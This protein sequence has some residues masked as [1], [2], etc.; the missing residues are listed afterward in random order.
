MT[1]STLQKVS[2]TLIMIAAIC[3]GSPAAM[4]EKANCDKVRFGQVNWTGVSTKTETAA[5]MLEQMGYETDVITGSLPIMFESLA[6]DERDFFLGWWVPSQREMATEYLVQGEMDIVT[7]NLKGAKYTVG[8]NRAAWEAGVRSFKELDEYKNKFEGSILGIEAGS[9]GNKIIRK[10][11]KN[12]VYGLGDWELRP[13]SEA[14]MLTEVRRRT[15]DGEWSAWLAW[16]PHPMVLNF[17]LEFLNG[18]AEYW[19][20]NQGGATVY[21]L[22]RSGHAWRCPNVG[23]FIEN[24]TF[25]VEEQSRMTGYVI[26]DDMDYAEA[27]RKLIKDKPEL[28][29]RW[30]GSAGTYQTGAVKTYDGTEAAKKVIAEALGL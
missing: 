26:N 23:Q 20:P 7:K 28:L 15:E 10:M 29:E 1:Q 9:G 8:V 2:T 25:T 18:A 17:D 19:G 16:A 13:S 12:D 11:I 5:W 4:A 30:F 6:T 27:G 14:G 22:S 21:A 3:A 24:Y